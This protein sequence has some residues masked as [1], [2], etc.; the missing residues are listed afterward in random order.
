MQ[1]Y[2]STTLESW[3]T[4]GYLSVA[5]AL[6]AEA[7]LIGFV[8]FA[9]LFTLETLLPTFVAV[10][11][12]LASF[13]I[14]LLLASF[15]LALLGRYLSIDFVSGLRRRNPLLWIGV[16]WA[17]GILA[18]S[19]FKFPLFLIPILILAFLGIG[20]LFLTLFFDGKD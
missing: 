5:Y 11:L 4:R 20:Y 2:I 18:I 8:M 9:A 16:L 14:I 3:K 17:V 7:L 1:R 10:R 6:L 15:L 19:L 13:L 12:N